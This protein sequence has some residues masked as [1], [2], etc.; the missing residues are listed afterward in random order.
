MFKLKQ[1]KLSLNKY[2]QEY[3]DKLKMGKCFGEK[4]VFRLS[5]GNGMVIGN[6]LSLSAPDNSLRVP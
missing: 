6:A 3:L 4:T 5:F 1:T 2:F